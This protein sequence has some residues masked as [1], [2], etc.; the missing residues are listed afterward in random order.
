MKIYQY[1][2]KKRDD[3]KSPKQISK[4]FNKNLWTVYAR[5]DSK[6]A[7]YRWGVRLYQM[8]DKSFKRFVRKQ[9]L[10]L[11]EKDRDHRGRPIEIRKGDANE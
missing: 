5:F 8:P 7:Q 6:Y 11:W 2:N 10:R 9:D 4:L 1:G 3:L